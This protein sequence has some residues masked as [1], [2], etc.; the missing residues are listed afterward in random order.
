MFENFTF[1]AA[2]TNPY[3]CDDDVQP[4]P[5]DD[6]FPVPISPSTNSYPFFN[7]Y[8]PSSPLDEIINQF[9]QQ[10]LSYEHTRSTQ[11]RQ[12]ISPTP[13]LSED[14]EM[15]SPINATQSVPTTPTSPPRNGVSTCRRLQRQLNVQLQCSNS[16]A[17]DISILLEDMLVN[18]SQ[19]ILRKS[20][21]KD[22]IG[23][24]PMF[25]LEVDC[26]TQ[27]DW[28]ELEALRARRRWLHTVVNDVDA[29][30]VEG[31]NWEKVDDCLS[32]R[33]AS[34]PSG[35]R[36]HGLRCRTSMESVGGVRSKVAKAPRMRIRKGKAERVV[37]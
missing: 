10:S 7:D 32:L 30:H 11:S 3:Q 18:N 14:S 20:P 19:C 35:I 34:T 9:D 29:A 6:S 15:S 23:Y 27:N 4:S 5:R 25:P 12:Y 24:S 8:N 21:S 2:P 16:H 17:R 36:K 33:R 37:E 31:G 1:G 22:S 26:G 13:S 28:N